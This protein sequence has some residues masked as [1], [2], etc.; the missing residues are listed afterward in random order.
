MAL[1]HPRDVSQDSCMR[2]RG[3]VSLVLVMM[4][5]LVSAC[6]GGSTEKPGAPSATTSSAPVATTSSSTTI[7]TSVF[8][9]AVWPWIASTVRFRDPAGAARS[10]ATAYL[11][12]TQPVI[13]AFRQGD[14]RSGE[15]D[16]RASMTGPVTT[17]IVRQLGSDGTWWVLGAATNNIRL[18]T[19]TA[20]ATITSPV[21]VR[22]TSTAFE[23][24]VNLS[25]RQDNS[26]SPLTESYVM[27]GSNGRMGPFAASISYPRPTSSAGSIVLY[28][29]SPKDGHVAEASVI[30]V[31]FVST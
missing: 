29:I 30:R 19:P 10:F 4:L 11:H 26:S 3:R 9:P 23:A 20:L 6:G 1:S 27:G 28:T 14:S 5:V 7:P 21:A 12:M 18:T 17:V 31:R 24:S 16:I 22:G 8:S 15:V 2:N 25:I 13:G